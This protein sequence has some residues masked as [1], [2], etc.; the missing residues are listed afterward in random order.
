MIT[1]IIKNLTIVLS[2]CCLFGCSSYSCPDEPEITPTPEPTVSPDPLISMDN[3]SDM[4]FSAIENKS[5]G[6]GFKKEKGKE[7]DIPEKDRELFRKYNSFYIDEKRDKVL[8]LTFDEGYE[9]GYTAQILDT[10]KEYNV[11]AAFFVTGPYLDKEQE[12][13]NRM[14]SEGHIVGNHTVHHPNLPKLISAQ[15]MASE[16]CSLNEKFA[17]SYG[18]RQMKYMR[19]PE[20]EYSERLLAVANALGFKT[21][22][23]SFAYKDWDPSLQKGSSY[24]FEQ[25]TPYLHDG[26]ILLLHAVSKDNAD[27]LA[28]IIQ[29]AQNEGYQFKNLDELSVIS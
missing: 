13:V 5:H 10:L 8:Y 15:K 19:P 3:I 6:W 29:Y 23:W 4:D 9:N 2:L 18:G 14:L 25:V 21:I 28:D 1:K 20:G 26:A 7:P 27:A 24:A 11:P 17:A 12:L 16:L 22:L